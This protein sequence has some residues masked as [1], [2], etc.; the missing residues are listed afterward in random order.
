[1]LTV[2]F[3]EN[4]Q[5]LSLVPDY[6][7]LRE[8]DKE[9]LIALKNLIKKLRKPNRIARQLRGLSLF[10]ICLNPRLSVD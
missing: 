8:D 1:M 5:F 4:G 2:T 6:E 3:D 10:F 7:Y 9:E